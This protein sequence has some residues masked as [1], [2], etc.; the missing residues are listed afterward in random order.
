M[1]ATKTKT[2]TKKPKTASYKLVMVIDGRTYKSTGKTVLDALSSLKVDG[3]SRGRAVLTATHGDK[4]REKILNPTMVNRLL[5][6]SPT[7]RQIALKNI[8]LLF[9]I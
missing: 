9:D 1:P 5:H 2:A 6:Q 8:S 4:T 3:L 7:F